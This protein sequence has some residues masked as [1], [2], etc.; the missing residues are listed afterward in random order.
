MGNADKNKIIQRIL[1]LCATRGV[2]KYR[3]AKESQ[4][5]LTTLSN[6]IRNNTMPTV[7]T[8]E[9]ICSGLGIT[10]GQFFASEEIYDSLTDEQREILEIWNSLNNHQKDLVKA[11][12]SGLI[13]R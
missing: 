8:I 7:P 12:I 9:R 1:E 5:P 11:Y 10:L 4:I 6:M 13:D 2:S 3:L